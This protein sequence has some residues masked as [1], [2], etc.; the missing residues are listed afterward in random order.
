MKFKNAIIYVQYHIVYDAADP[1]IKVKVAA[2]L[3]NLYPFTGKLSGPIT[4]LWHMAGCCYTRQI[5]SSRIHKNNL[6]ILSP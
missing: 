2:G 5:Y 1:R 3:Q 6:Y 4:Q